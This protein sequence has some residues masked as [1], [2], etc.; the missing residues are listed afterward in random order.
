[1]I[2]LSFV[3]SNPGKYREVREL[4]RPYD[5]RVRWRR[6][7]LP[8]PQADSLDTVV[9]AKL[10]AVRKLPGYVLVEDSGLF[11]PSLNGFP[12]VISSH[13][14]RIWRFQPILD[15]LRTRNRR[16]FYRTVAGLRK[17]R[18]LWTFVGEC[19]GSIARR[20]RGT[21]GFGFDPIF[22][23]EKSR[24]TFAEMTEDQKNVCSHR[25]LATKAVARKLTQLRNNQ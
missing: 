13:I 3:T 16:A 21:G 14:Y 4:L 20:S 24:L 5:I 22:I 19:H 23:P 7:T 11:I 18:N 12:G 25:S 17:G 6:Q 10:E 1:M 9:R 2:D 8:E 15:L